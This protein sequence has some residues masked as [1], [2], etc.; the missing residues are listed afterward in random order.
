MGEAINA[1]AVY[2]KVMH[3]DGKF[4][5][6]DMNDIAKIG[7][8]GKAQIEGKNCTY[9]VALIDW[10]TPYTDQWQVF[11]DDD[12]LTLWKNFCSKPQKS[13]DK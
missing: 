1:N 6:I 5:L 11:I 8:G 10:K 2:I 9:N 3:N 4:T 13:V 12:G 7:I